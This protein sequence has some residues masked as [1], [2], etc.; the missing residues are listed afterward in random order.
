[1]AGFEEQGFGLGPGIEGRFVAE[2]FDGADAL[3]DAG[4]GKSDESR[5]GSDQN[6]LPFAGLRAR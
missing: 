5:F 1:M 2:Q 6:E 4:A 3:D